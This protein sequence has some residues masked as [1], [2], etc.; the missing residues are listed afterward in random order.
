MPTLT[1]HNLDKYCANFDCEV[2]FLLS[3]KRR[4]FCVFLHIF[5][6]IISA[7]I[8]VAKGATRFM[9]SWPL[10][11]VGHYFRPALTPRNSVKSCPNFDSKYKFL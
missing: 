3:V 1:P 9:F 8:L 4:V 2:I 7:A 5:C 10:I 6:D 11:L